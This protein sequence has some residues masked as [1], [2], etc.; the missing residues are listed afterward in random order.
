MAVCK[1]KP[2]DGKAP[3]GAVGGKPLEI[4]WKRKHDK[5]QHACETVPNVAVGHR[6][7]ESSDW[8]I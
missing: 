1:M 6:Y 2:E 3:V 4:H 8:F 5:P 7:A